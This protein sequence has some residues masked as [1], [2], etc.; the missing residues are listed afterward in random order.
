MAVE[1][2]FFIVHLSA[3]LPKPRNLEEEDPTAL[4]SIYSF[5]IQNNTLPETNVSPENGWLEYKP[6]LLGWPIFRGELLVLGRIGFGMIP[7]S[8][9]RPS[10]RGHSKNPK[11]RGT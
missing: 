3:C 1:H 9:V 11:N 2:P 10:L 5:K 6:F 4:M 8:P 7:Q